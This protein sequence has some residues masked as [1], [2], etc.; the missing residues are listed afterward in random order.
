MSEAPAGKKAPR[1]DVPPSGVIPR[2]A[3]P[4]ARSCS[5]MLSAEG[6]STRTG[7]GSNCARSAPRRP[8]ARAVGARRPRL[9]M[10]M[11]DGGSS[12]V[13]SRRSRRDRCSMKSLHNGSGGRR[14]T[15]A[16]LPP[17]APAAAPCSKTVAKL[18]PPTPTST[19]RAHTTPDDSRAAISAT[20]LSH[21]AGASLS[22]GSSSAINFE[23]R[24]GVRSSMHARWRGA[25]PAPLAAASASRT[26]RCLWRRM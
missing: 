8:K 23:T 16:A 20:E 1:S 3:W 18:R 26:Q 13:L 10:R 7:S 24:C 17:A 21:R 15:E 2:G 4:T 12:S 6:S 19:R 9:V 11:T 14:R 25:E 22:A 5:R